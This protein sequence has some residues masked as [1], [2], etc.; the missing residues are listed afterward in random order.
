MSRIATSTLCSARLLSITA[1]FTD[2]VLQT[3]LRVLHVVENLDR[4][5]VENWL[6]RMLGHARKQEIEVD[7]T[8]YC[9]LE[10]P[11]AMDEKARALGARVIHSPVPIV[12]KA[13]FVARLAHGV[14]AWGVRRLAL[15]P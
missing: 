12:K 6:L 14:A 13:E 9:I 11:G 5:A 8:F 10:Q 3:I 4:G 2:A 7:W 15:P 1:S